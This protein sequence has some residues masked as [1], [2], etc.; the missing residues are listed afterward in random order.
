MRR[1][2][3]SDSALVAIVLLDVQWAQVLKLE[4]MRLLPTTKLRRFSFREPLTEP[5]RE[6]RRDEIAHRFD[7]PAPDTL[8]VQQTLRQ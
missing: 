1:R 7:I 5:M 8:I 4:R 3:G 6:V 2:R